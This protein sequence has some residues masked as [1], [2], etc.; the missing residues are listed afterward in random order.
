M[1]RNLFKTWSDLA[2]DE[3]TYW[4]EVEAISLVNNRPPC[5][6]RVGAYPSLVE[7]DALQGYLQRCI[8][9][10]GWSFLVQRSHDYCKAEVQT[11][12]GGQ[13]FQDEQRTH[14]CAE[15]LLTIY[16]SALAAQ[17]V[18]TPKS[19]W[20]Y[21]EGGNVNI[22]CA[23]HWDSGAYLDG[24]KDAVFHGRFC[25]EEEPTK[26]VGLFKDKDNFLYVSEYA[27]L[28]GD[29]VFYF[30]DEVGYAKLTESF[31]GLVDL[32]NLDQKGS[33]RFAEVTE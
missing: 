3:A 12:A 31:L 19:V 13:T 29:R 22:F 17:R 26:S 32:D 15:V 6:R 33:L 4:D 10:R 1:L 20:Q 8:H 28:S 9:A 27:I 16:L 2:P 24:Y 21:S 5:L 7:Q 18:I 25:I 14:V 30:H 23:A 11:T